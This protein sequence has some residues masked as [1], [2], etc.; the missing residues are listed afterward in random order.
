LKYQ[1]I[2]TNDVGYGRITFSETIV[3]TGNVNLKLLADEEGRPLATAAGNTLPV[4]RLYYRLFGIS[5]QK[6]KGRR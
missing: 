1:K 5:I 6:K 4:D 3:L 2:N